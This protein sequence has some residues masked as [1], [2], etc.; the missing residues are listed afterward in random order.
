MKYLF[1]KLPNKIKAGKGEGIVKKDA[2]MEAGK[3]IRMRD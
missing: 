3:V 2:C 1:V